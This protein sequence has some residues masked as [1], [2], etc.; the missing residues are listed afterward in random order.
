MDITDSQQ[1]NAFASAPTQEVQ[2]ES[3]AQ[4]KTKTSPTSATQSTSSTGDSKNTRRR[5]I[6]LSQPTQSSQPISL[7]KTKRV[8]ATNKETLNEDGLQAAGTL[9]NLKNSQE[10][11]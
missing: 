10:M 5:R 7:P 3:S 4:E 2:I 6:D 8:K 9:V 11:L 1:P